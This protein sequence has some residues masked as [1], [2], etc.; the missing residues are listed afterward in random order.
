MFK[1]GHIYMFQIAQYSLEALQIKLFISER[2]LQIKFS[3]FYLLQMQTQ[4]DKDINYN[5]YLR[6][7]RE[8]LMAYYTSTGCK[9]VAVSPLRSVFCE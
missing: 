7:L 9:P 5:K 6:R 8:I 1:A 3:D 2:N 4:T